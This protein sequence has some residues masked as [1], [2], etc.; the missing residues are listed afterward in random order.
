MITKP[1]EHGIAVGREKE[2]ERE[3]EE[4]GGRGGRMTNV[5]RLELLIYANQAPSRDLHNKSTEGCDV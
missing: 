5:P 1:I 2:R 3:R 4:R